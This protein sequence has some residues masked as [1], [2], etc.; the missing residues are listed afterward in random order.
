MLRVLIL[1]L[2]LGLAAK[3][4]SDINLPVF[5]T[6]EGFGTST[7]AGRGGEII[8]VTSLDDSGQGS[9]RSAMAVKGPR[10]I[11]FEVGGTIALSSE[12]II[13][14]PYATI[15]GQ[16]APSPGIT[17]KGAGLTILTHDVLIQHLRIRVGDA[18]GSPSPANRDALQ[19]LGTSAYNVVVDHISAS[20]AIDEN[21]ST[22]YGAHDLTIRCS[23]ISEGLNMSSHPKGPHSKGLLIG[24]HSK[25]VALIGNLLAHNAER[26]PRINGGVT[27]L[28]VNNLVY[29]SR[30]NFMSIGSKS[31]QSTVSALGNLFIPGPNTLPNAIPIKIERN[32]VPGTVVYLSDNRH[33]NK[34]IPSLLPSLSVPPVRTSPLKVRDSNTLATWIFTNAGA[35]P[36][37]RDAVD[38]RIIAEVANR[39]GRIIDSQKQVGGWPELKRTVRPFPI[40]TRPHADDDQDGYSNIEELLHQMAA[41]VE[42]TTSLL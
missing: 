32:A 21:F 24:D 9:L 23:V 38:Q 20:W 37:D 16:T 15:S 12:I 1:L 26:N 42:G 17:L 35:R 14:S 4:Y 40:P 29:N 5:P 34:I 30:Q 2:I 10:I 8:K 18:V 11:V 25:N 33:S 3:S 22:W 7:Q 19:I 41:Q 28:V 13:E 27:A 6:A 31:D 39:T 36:A